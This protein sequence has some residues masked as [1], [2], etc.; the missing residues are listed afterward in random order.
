M[1]GTKKTKT[2]AVVC[3]FS[4]IKETSTQK[5]TAYCIFTVEIK[6]QRRLNKRME[7]ERETALDREKVCN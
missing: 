2:G 6:K 5:C 1:E 3:G 7:I 4:S